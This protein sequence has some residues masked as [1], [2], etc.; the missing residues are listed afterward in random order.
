MHRSVCNVAH[1]ACDIADSLLGDTEWSGDMSDECA[2]MLVGIINHCAGDDVVKDLLDTCLLTLHFNHPG[3]K[4]Y[5]TSGGDDDEDSRFT[6]EDDLVHERVETFFVLCLDGEVDINHATETTTVCTRVG[7]CEAFLLNTHATHF[8]TSRGSTAKLLVA[9]CVSSAT[10][11]HHGD[12]VASPSSVVFDRYYGDNY[13]RYRVTKGETMVYD[14]VLTHK[15]IYDACTRRAL[16]AVHLSQVLAPLKLLNPPLPDHIPDACASQVCVRDL[17]ARSADAVFS[18]VPRRAAA[19]VC[20]HEC[21]VYTVQ[22][23]Y[24]VCL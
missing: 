1:P 22:I 7:V 14:L 3:Q 12:Y 21:T 20:E 15:R 4:Y 23:V 17:C 2:N 16:A 11:V 24:V 5:L 8:M 18:G 9:H 19:S 10:I 13:V 6:V